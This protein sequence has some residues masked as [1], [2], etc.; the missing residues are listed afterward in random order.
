M[1]NN[2]NNLFKS[3]LNSELQDVV[4]CF[5]HDDIGQYL[6]IKLADLIEWGQDKVDNYFNYDPVLCDILNDNED[7]SN[8]LNASK[9]CPCY[10]G[11]FNDLNTLNEFLNDNG[12]IKML[13]LLMED[14][15]D[16]Q[17][18]IDIIEK[19][20]YILYPKCYDNYD[21]GCYIFEEFY[22]YDYKDFPLINYI[23]Y[24]ALGRDHVLE[25]SGF[26]SDA[27]YIEYI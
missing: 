2:L 1:N 16:I 15:N 13:N 27:G 19:G 3:E 10:G 9:Y 22:N 4:L 14:L 7:L 21:V 11:L 23:D 24:E 17:E 8:I 18:A 6:N 25:T 5:C 20:N 12:D 26:F